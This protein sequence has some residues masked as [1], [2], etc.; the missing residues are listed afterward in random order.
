MSGRVR[1]LELRTHGGGGGV[2]ARTHERR[3]LG[4]SFVTFS[5]LFLGAT[6]ED[7]DKRGACGPLFCVFFYYPSCA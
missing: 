2:A 5:F 1:G 7:S 3:R 4:C 6:W